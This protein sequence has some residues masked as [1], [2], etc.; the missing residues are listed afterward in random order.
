MKQLKNGRAPGVDGITEMLKTKL[1]ARI[2][3]WTALLAV[4]WNNKLVPKH[5]TWG[6]VVKLF[7]KGD[8]LI[9]DSRRGIK[10]QPGRFC[11]DL[12]F[13]LR[14]RVE[15]LKEWDKK[16]TSFIDF[17]KEFDSVDPKILWNILNY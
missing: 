1:L 9:C 6:K 3:V 15:E 2:T 17:E 10:L 8:A 14:L 7:K 5:W 12:V 16:Y 13:I 4:A 11:S